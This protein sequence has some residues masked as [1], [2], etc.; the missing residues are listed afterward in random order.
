MP[1]FKR[2]YV[3][4]C[5]TLLCILTAALPIFAQEPVGE[6]QGGEVNLVVPD[7]TRVT[8]FGGLNGHA[9][10]LFGLLI[11]FLGLVFG[12][13]IYQKLKSLPVHLSM[14]EVSELIY[15]TCKTYLVTQG[16]FLMVL[17]V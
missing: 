12:L 6:H 17:W 16:K 9:L 14:K 11:P 15:E 3:M 2:G 7:L 5:L 10:L 4:T 8:F 13:I 1:S